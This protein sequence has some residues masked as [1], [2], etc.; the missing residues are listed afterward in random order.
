MD[1]FTKTVK[2]AQIK[3]KQKVQEELVLRRMLQGKEKRKN[4]TLQKN[5]ILVILEG[6]I[7]GLDDTLSSPI[8]CCIRILYS[9][10][11]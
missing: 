8:F 9:P 11:I 6:C 10:D 7:S 1:G 3:T 4:E 2:V 5:S